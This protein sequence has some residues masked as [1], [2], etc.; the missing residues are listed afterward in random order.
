MAVSDLVENITFFHQDRG[1]NNEW[2]FAA[3]SRRGR[4]NVKEIVSTI[5]LTSW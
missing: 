2:G 1:A 5:R 4:E 3:I